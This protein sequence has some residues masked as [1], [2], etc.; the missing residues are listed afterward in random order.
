LAAKCACR[1]VGALQQVGLDSYLSHPLFS[2]C[3]TRRANMRISPGKI[4]LKIIIKLCKKNKKK[5]LKCEKFNQK[6]IKK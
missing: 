3:T 5:A 4:K 2:A 1:H 6:R